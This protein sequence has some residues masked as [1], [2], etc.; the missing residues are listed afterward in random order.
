MPKLGGSNVTLTIDG[1][2][3]TRFVDVPVIRAPVRLQKLIKPT[4]TALSE[5]TWH[6]WV[7]PINSNFS[8]ILRVTW[9][10]P[11]KRQLRKWRRAV[12][13]NQH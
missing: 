1:V 2:P 3:A 5:F 10:K 12:R 13:N 6:L 11:T 9:T 8:H 7:T 4:F